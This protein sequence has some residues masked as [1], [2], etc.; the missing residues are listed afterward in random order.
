V[1]LPVELKSYIEWG[2]NALVK[3]NESL[4]LPRAGLDLFRK[5]T[6]ETHMGAAPI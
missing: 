5:T 1:N 2:Q 4:Q 3:K 6:V